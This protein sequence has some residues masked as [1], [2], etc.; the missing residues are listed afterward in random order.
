MNRTWS[1]PP[2]NRGISR[3]EKHL[4]SFQEARAAE[5]K[6]VTGV[7][8]MH[9]RKPLAGLDRGEA[10]IRDH[11]SELVS[12]ELLKDEGKQWQTG[13]KA[14]RQRMMGKHQRMQSLR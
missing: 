13:G 6:S 5:V 10:K 14:L 1:L 8:G 4:K 3:E 11:F 9:C 12:T 2:E 7:I